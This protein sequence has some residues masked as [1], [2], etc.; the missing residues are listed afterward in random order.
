M[1]PALNAY[2]R[3]VQSTGFAALDPAVMKKVLPIV[4]RES[5]SYRSTGKL[6]KLL[7]QD[8]WTY[9]NLSVNLVGVD[10]S[11]FSYRLEQ[12]LYRNDLGGGTTG[13]FWVSYNHLLG[14]NAH[15]L[16]GKFDAPAPSPFSYWSDQSGFSSASVA[17][18]QHTYELS[19]QRWGVGFNYV[20]LNPAKEP[21]KVQLA[22]LGNNPPMFNASAFDS[23][24]PYAPFAAG[25]DK[26]FQYK[27]AWARAD[28]PV[29]AGVYGAVGT[30]ILSTG[31]VNPI[32][33][34]SAAGVYAQRD[35]RNGFPGVFVFYQR[36]YD[37]NVGPGA[38]KNL[39]AQG[40]ASWAGGLEFDQPLLHGNVMLGIRPVEYISGLQASK[41]GYDTLA[42]AHPHYGAFDIVARDP[43]ISPY[44]YLTIESAVAAA[45]NANFSQPA[46]RFGLKWAA[47]VAPAPRN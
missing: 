42:T 39:L 9:A 19:A 20:P 27:A 23:S 30:Y 31:Y 35:P 36:T 17:V 14:G 6:D 33:S 8:K 10:S 24:N 25:S 26:A 41:A 7:P 34:Y 13:H 11:S 18:G 44:L 37:S 21:V 16:V 2:G 3:F 22:Y 12:S 38:A 28:N 1:V 46:W 47:P 32:D 43:K 40:A 4:V 15:L 45:S 5:L 29:E